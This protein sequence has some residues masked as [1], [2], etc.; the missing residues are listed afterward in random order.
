MIQGNKKVKLTP[1]SVL[2]KISE[3]DIFRFY[4]LDKTWKLNQ[5]T[6]SPFRKEQN[7]SF[8]IGN[9]NGNLSFIDFADTSKP[10]SYTHLTLPT[11]RIV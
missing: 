6:Y 1:D 8:V 7:P 9:K 2:S 3:Y 4:M 5:V 10:V 11:K